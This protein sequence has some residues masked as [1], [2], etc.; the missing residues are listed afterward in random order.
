L[1]IT[2]DQEK[3][4]IMQSVMQS[5]AQEYMEKGRVEG[6]MEVAKKLFFELHLDR[7]TVQKTT[8]LSEKELQSIIKK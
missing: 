6:M 5:V 8:G 1:L 4:E 2:N 3:E 7:D